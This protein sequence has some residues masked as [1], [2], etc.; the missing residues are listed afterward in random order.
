MGINPKIYISATRLKKHIFNNFVPNIV[1]YN[2]DDPININFKHFQT[3]AP[4]YAENLETSK[5]KHQENLNIPKFK[6]NTFKNG[7]DFEKKIMEKIN[8]LFPNDIIR[9]FQ[10]PKDVLSTEKYEETQ[11][12]I[13]INAPII[14]HG[15]L[16]NHTNGT[17]GVPDII[18][19]GDYLNK[20]IPVNSNK[21][22]YHIVDIKNTLIHIDT[23]MN[24]NTEDTKWTFYYKCQ[25]YLYNEALNNIQPNSTARSF[26]ISNQYYCNNKLFKWNEKITKVDFSEKDRHI[27]LEFNELCNNLRRR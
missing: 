15:I 18:I 9:V 3:P 10:F 17:F 4:Q 13:K 5:P 12:Y 14:Y 21:N 20:I 8:L 25:L 26:I 1:K 7:L 6:K 11:Y 16:H 27:E 24:I 19:R 23:M 22:V 2:F